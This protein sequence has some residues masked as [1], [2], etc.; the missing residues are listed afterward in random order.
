MQEEVTKK[1]WNS[2]FSSLPDGTLLILL[3][4]QCQ[5]WLEW[6]QNQPHTPF[7]LKSVCPTPAPSL[8]SQAAESIITHPRPALLPPSAASGNLQHLRVLPLGEK[9]FPVSATVTWSL[10]EFLTHLQH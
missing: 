7:L 6:E 3:P 9:S 8:H 2:R 4:S 10:N 5:D 1:W